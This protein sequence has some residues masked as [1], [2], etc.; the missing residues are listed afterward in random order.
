[1]KYVL[2]QWLIFPFLFNI[3]IAQNQNCPEYL[4]PIGGITDGTFKAN[5][6]VNSNGIILQNNTV[7]F[8]AGQSIELRN[9]FAT[10][11]NTNFLAEVENCKSSVAASVNA[12]SFSSVP[13]SVSEGT[14]YTVEVN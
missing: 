6:T 2:L 4:Q 7:E 11:G 8:K 1:M 14:A 5:N 10:K 3:C 13:Q 12:L 9:G